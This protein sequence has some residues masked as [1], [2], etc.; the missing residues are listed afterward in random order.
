[1][2]GKSKREIENE[3]D[4]VKAMISKVGKD[5]ADLEAELD[6]LKTRKKRLTAELQRFQDEEEDGRIFFGVHSDY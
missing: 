3:L 2:R 6:R 5:K 4:Y 1:M